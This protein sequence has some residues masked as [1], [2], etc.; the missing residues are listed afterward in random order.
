MAGLPK[1]DYRKLMMHTLASQIFLFDQQLLQTQ[2]RP[3]SGCRTHHKP[4]MKQTEQQQ[5][6]DCAQSNQNV[7]RG[8]NAGDVIR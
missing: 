5:S 2:I 6:E 3:H 7:E 1:Y 4:L 8:Y